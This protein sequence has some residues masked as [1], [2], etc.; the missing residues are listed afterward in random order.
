MV[1]TCSRRSVQEALAY[2][3]LVGCCFVSHFVCMRRLPFL[4]L[5]PRLCASAGVSPCTFFAIKY[6]L[7]KTTL[8]HRSQ[9]PEF[10]VSVI[11]YGYVFFLIFT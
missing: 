1:F 5:S 11:N 6:L 10:H 7:L 4:F 8:L 2:N 3:P 9:H